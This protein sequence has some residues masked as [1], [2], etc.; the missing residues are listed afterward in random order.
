MNYGY[1]RTTK[2]KRH[3]HMRNGSMNIVSKISKVIYHDLPHLQKQNNIPEIWPNQIIRK[4][5]LSTVPM[6]RLFHL[7]QRGFNTGGYQ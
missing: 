1:G 6:P 2:Q 4:K 3:G 5:N 7:Y